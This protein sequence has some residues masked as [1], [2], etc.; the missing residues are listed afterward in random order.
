MQ[1][2]DVPEPVV[3]GGA[4]DRILQRLV[5]QTLMDDTELVTEVPKISWPAPPPRAGLATQMAEQ[6]VEVTVVSALS[7]VLVQME[8][9]L[10][11]VP[12]VES[13]SELQ[14][15]SVEPNVDIP[16]HGGV[17]RRAADLH[18]FLPGPSPTACGWLVP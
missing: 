2:L 3:L 15:H 14:Q 17:G 5:E 16:V 6:L 8:N 18:G 9:Q 12:V 10:A 11:E 1:I 4:Q 13:L 7:C